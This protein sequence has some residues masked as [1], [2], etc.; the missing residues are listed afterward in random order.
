M[1]VYTFYTVHS[2][3]QKKT[4][5]TSSGTD[6]IVAH[7]SDKRN[8][9]LWCHQTSINFRLHICHLTLTIFLHPQ[10]LIVRKKY[11]ATASTASAA[12][13][14]SLLPNSLA[15]D[16]SEW[17]RVCISGPT[18]FKTF[19]P[20]AAKNAKQW[21]I[22]NADNESRQANMCVRMGRVCVWISEKV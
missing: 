18:I 14:S 11:T 19:V 10:L 5:N 7:G 16:F 2:L 20:S 9:F 22:N 12:D 13:I 21:N 8:I 6:F 17:L 1:Q 3:P 4:A 15:S